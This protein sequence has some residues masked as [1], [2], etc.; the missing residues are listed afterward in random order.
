MKR[1][2]PRRG[3]SPHRAGAAAGVR[4]VVDGYTVVARPGQTTIR[5][6]NQ[7]RTVED[8]TVGRRVHVKGTK[9]GLD[10]SGC[11]VQASEVEVQQ[12]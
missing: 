10:D 4:S 3:D 12:T 11:R 8:V 9:R 6:G 1:P 2:R 7:A 5:E